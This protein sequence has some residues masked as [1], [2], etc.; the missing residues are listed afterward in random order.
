MHDSLMAD[1]LRMTNER[2]TQKIVRTRKGGRRLSPPGPALTSKSTKDCA[3]SARTKVGRE[4]PRVPSRVAL[5]TGLDSEYR[6][7]HGKTKRDK[8]DSI[9]RAREYS[10]HPGL[11]SR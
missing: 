11:R 3:L 9:E 6:R 4:I 8:R 1:Y 7:V 2:P 5:W 10:K